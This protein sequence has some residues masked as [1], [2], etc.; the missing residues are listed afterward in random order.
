[1]GLV[2]CCIDR[3]SFLLGSLCLVVL[4]R[5]SS[6][7]SLAKLSLCRR[8]LGIDY[9]RLYMFSKVAASLLWF[10]SFGAVP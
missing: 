7:S 2:R 1:M 10:V 9:V 5:Y 6:P 3:G 4:W 8:L